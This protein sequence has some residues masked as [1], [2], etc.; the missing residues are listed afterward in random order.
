MILS[1]PGNHA[2]LK[3]RLVYFLVTGAVLTAGYLSRRWSV[4]GSFIHDYAGDA[5][6]AA[7]IYFGFRFLLVRATPQRAWIAAMITTWFIEVTQLYQAAWLN[8]IRHTWL[9]GLIL[10]YSFLWSDLLMYS[11]G[12]GAAWAT[13]RF[14]LTKIR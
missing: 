3:K 6:W 5:V 1:D 9:G 11:L 7:M 8:A 2:L 10:G 14:F 13:D 4:K 12:I